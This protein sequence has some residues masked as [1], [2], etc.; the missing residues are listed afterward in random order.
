LGTGGL[1]NPGISGQA[2]PDTLLQALNVSFADGSIRR[3]GGTFRYA[4]AI[5]TYTSIEAGMDFWPTSST[6]FQVIYASSGSNSVVLRDA[7][8]GAFT[9]IDGPDAVTSDLPPVF[10]LGGSENPGN[11]KKLFLFRNSRTCRVLSGDNFSMTTIGGTPMA[12]P[13]AGPNPVLLPTGGG[14]APGNVDDGAHVYSVTYLTSTGET[15]DTVGPSQVYVPDKTQL[16]VVQVREIVIGGP[17]T[18]GRR[19]YR[20]KAVD[21]YGARFLLTT[22]SNNTQTEFV[23]NVSDAALSTTQPPA[24]NTTNG[25]PLEW[26][27]TNW[28]SVGCLHAGRLWAAGNLNDPHALY[29][30]T[31]YDHE[32]FVSFGSARLPVFPGEGQYIV[33]LLS[34]GSLL[35]VWKYPVGIYTVDT[36]N[37]DVGQWRID[38]LT[39]A[40]GGLNGVTQVQTHNDVLFLDPEGELHFLSAIQE[41]TSLRGESLS[42]AA[43]VD[44]LF[45][46]LADSG[47]LIYAKLL[48]Y[49]RKREAHL[50]FRRTGETVNGARFVIDFNQPNRP[51]FRY[52]DRD[53]CQALWIRLEKTVGQQQQRLIIGDNAGN[54]DILDEPTTSKNAAGYTSRF[55]TMWNDLGLPN[56]DKNSD[57]LELHLNPAGQDPVRV[58]VLWDSQATLDTTIAQPALA[59]PT[60]VRT[61]RLRAPGG[62]RRMSLEIEQTAAGA[63]FSVARALMSFTPRA[64]RAKS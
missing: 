21:P 23:D 54:V 39:T 41:Y 38:S 19:L 8:N 25:R 55:Q 51:R 53:I 16:G 9:V 56:T 36:S 52:S 6:H 13:F 15:T 64:E 22:I 1:I 61:Y 26:S 34:L 3:E 31:P 43:Q 29:A 57:F 46:S 30:S 7:N 24:V 40:Y 48:Y 33:G 63:N 42:R 14:G 60:H 20:S 17:N 59:D 35:I 27:G 58:R 49:A 44:A 18:T 32:N 10:V 12:P 2:P 50:S 45:R 4:A 62:G 5:P 47:G 28:P 11:P 37:L